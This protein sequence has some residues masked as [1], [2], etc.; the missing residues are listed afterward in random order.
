MSDRRAEG[1]AVT[2]WLSHADH[3]RARLV[4]QSYGLSVSALA[5]MALL[6][7]L[8]DEDVTAETPDLTTPAWTATLKTKH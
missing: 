7:L 4:A 2:A 1:R 3:Q 5:A 6:D 8:D